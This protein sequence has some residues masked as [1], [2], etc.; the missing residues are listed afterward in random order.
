M[1]IVRYNGV[2]FITEEEIDQEFTGQWVLVTTDRINA[3][4]GYLVASA[5]GRDELRS[6]LDDIGTEEYGGKAKIKYG[7]R[8]RGG[9]MN[10][11]L[12]G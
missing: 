11:E 9:S 1:D 12:L 2:R 3:H 4:E 7:C 8:E 10:V 5:E 6:A